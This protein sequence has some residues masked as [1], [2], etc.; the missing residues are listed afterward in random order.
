[1]GLL[2][3]LVLAGRHGC[4]GLDDR[5]GHVGHHGAGGGPGHAYWPGHAGGPGRYGLDERPGHVGHHGAGGGPWP[6]SPRIRTAHLFKNSP[7]TAKQPFGLRGF[8]LPFPT[9]RQWVGGA[10]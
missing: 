9:G 8:A 4:Y 7:R 10:A 3:A 6:V 5:P 2:T 1:M